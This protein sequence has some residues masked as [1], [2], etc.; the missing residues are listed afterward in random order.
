MRGGI[1]NPNTFLPS[2][3][4][5]PHLTLPPPHPNTLSHTLH[6]HPMHSPAPLFTLLHT[7]PIHPSHTFSRFFRKYYIRSTLPEKIGKAQRLKTCYYCITKVKFNKINLAW[8]YKTLIHDQRRMHGEVS[9]VRTAPPPPPI[10]Y[11]KRNK[12]F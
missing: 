6:T 4:H 5:S 8:S 10:D 1:E 12:N 2:L 3:L 11:W 7:H 9:E